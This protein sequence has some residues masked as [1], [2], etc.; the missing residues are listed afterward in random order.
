M[1]ER[2]AQVSNNAAKVTPAQSNISRNEA[3]Q[4]ES[5]ATSGY[6]MYIFHLGILLKLKL[7]A[8]RLST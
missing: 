2:L 1:A 6:M 7:K 5:T 4:I 3:T 8:V